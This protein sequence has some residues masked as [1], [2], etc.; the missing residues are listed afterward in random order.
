MMDVPASHR[1]AAVETEALER[2]ALRQRC[3]LEAVFAAQPQLAPTAMLAMRQDRAQ[4]RA[5]LAAYRANALAHATNALR[6]QFP[7]VHAMLGS[8]SFD[9]VCIRHWRSRPPRQGDLA[10]AGTD[11]PQTVCDH[12]DLRPWPWLGDCARLDLALW[13]VLFEPPAALEKADLD[14]LITNDPQRLRMQL[15]PGNRLI[16]SAWPIVTLWQMHREAEP[17]RA[18]L[19][20]ALQ[21]CGET[22]WVWR[23]GLQAQCVALGPTH[24]QWLRALQV[25]PTLKAALDAT[26]EDFDAIAWLQAAVRHGWLQAVSAIGPVAS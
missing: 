25:H 1:S 18:A 13:A 11:F 20:A 5:G 7:T 17:D 9:A 10:W 6:A 3:L 22:A 21:Q 24:A 2:E 8:E 12:E 15:A 14:R 23:E 16:A 4:W 26:P 19:E